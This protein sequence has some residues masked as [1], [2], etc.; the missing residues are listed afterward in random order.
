MILKQSTSQLIM[1]LAKSC[2]TK[3]YN[4]QSQKISKRQLAYSQPKSKVIFRFLLYFLH[5]G[6]P[7]ILGNVNRS[8]QTAQII[9]APNEA[10]I[11]NLHLANSLYFLQSSLDSIISENRDHLSEDTKIILTNAKDQ[12]GPHYILR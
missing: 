4:L 10:Q 5:L 3:N 2:S 11:Q 9:S 8:H 6:L 12:L 1:N 7:L